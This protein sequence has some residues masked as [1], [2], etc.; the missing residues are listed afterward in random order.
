MSPLLL[1]LWV[2][3]MSVLA[4]ALPV[5]ARWAAQ[6]PAGSDPLLANPVGSTLAQG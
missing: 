5:W 1:V 6:R 3:A 4:S 2:I